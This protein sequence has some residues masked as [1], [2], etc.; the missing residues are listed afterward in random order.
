M[1]EPPVYFLSLRR[2]AHKKRGEVAG[3]SPSSMR[4]EHDGQGYGHGHGVYTGLHYICKLCTIIGHITIDAILEGL[5]SAR[6]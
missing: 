5:F 4:T 6:D 2:F 1:Y 3:I